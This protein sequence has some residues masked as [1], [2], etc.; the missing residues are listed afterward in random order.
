MSKIRVDL[1]ERSYDIHIERGLLR[2]I[3]PRMKAL[4]LKGPAAVITNPTVDALYGKSVTDSLS[5]SGFTP[6]VINV[7]D[8]EEYKSLSEASKVFDILIENR[9]ERKSPIVAL[10]GGVIG[11]LSG[12][13]A[14]TYLRGVPYIQAPTTLLSQVDSSVGGKTAVNHPKGKNLIGAFYQPRAV[15]IDPDVLKTLDEREIKAGLAEV[16]KYGIIRDLEFFSFLEENA[17]KLLGPGDEIIRCIER[18]CEIKAEIVGKDEKEENLRAILNF[19]HTFGHAIEALSGYGSYRHGE[20]VA[21][22]MAMAAALSAR[23]GLCTECGTRITALLSS[24]GM[25]FSPPEIKPKDFID[26]MRLDKKVS[27]AAIRFVLVE[28]MGEVIVREV[29]EEVLLELLASYARS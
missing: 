11:D 29:G 22:G 19:G 4:G 23:L 1:A 5:A 13:I 7:P 15:F 10:G 20:A 28:R 17:K 16:I 25:P 8:G 2:E 3:G 12:F 26:A 14:A 6:F 21:I 9:F 27:G 18:S 24:F